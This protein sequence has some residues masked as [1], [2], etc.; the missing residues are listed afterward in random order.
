MIRDVIRRNFLLD[1][2]S[3]FFKKVNE[4]AY[5]ACKPNPSDPD[6]KQMSIKEVPKNTLRAKPVTFQ[7]L[8]PRFENPIR[9]DSA[10]DMNELNEFEKMY[11]STSIFE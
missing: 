3:R 9:G 4:F 5:I 8:W 11:G 1:L 7:N 2:K 6:V 10:T